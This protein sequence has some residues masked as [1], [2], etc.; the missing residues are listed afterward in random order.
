MSTVNPIKHSTYVSRAV[1]H[2]QYFNKSDTE[3]LQTVLSTQYSVLAQ[4]WSKTKL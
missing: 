1:L 2:M 3:F 4:T